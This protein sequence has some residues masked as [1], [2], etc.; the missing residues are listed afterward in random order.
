MY[1]FLNEVNAKPKVWSEYT[2]KELWTEPHISSQML[3]YHLN[4]EVDAASRSYWFID[5]SVEWMASTLHLNRDSCIIDLGCGPGLYTTR[6]A[7]KG[8]QNITGVD[9]SQRSI[10]FAR[11]TA[12]EEGLS[13]HYVVQNYLNFQS[14]KKFDLVTMI[15][16]D[17]CALSPAQR[18]QLLNVVSS[19]LKP[20]GAFVFDV[21]T[22]RA[23]ERK[24]ESASYEFGQMNGF[25]SP[26]EYYGFLNTFLYPDEMVS[27]DKYTIVEPTRTW[28]IYNWL[29]HFTLESLSQ[30]L[31]SC[32]LVVE[33]VYGD[34]AGA[35]YSEDTEEMAIIV[36]NQNT[37]T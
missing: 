16:C 22:Q 30:E 4:P 29:Q 8:I 32:H 21:Y 27:L 17:F 9:F 5:K 15:M 23:L 1:H 7:K 13:I 31:A 18:Q 33:E 3:A 11:K 12:K 36:R 25:W 19:I 37:E 24:K 35:N 10:D 2:A 6:F 26:T 34:I 14:D 28:N 20:N